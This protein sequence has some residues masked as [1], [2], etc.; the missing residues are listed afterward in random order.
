MMLP[1]C[2]G[3]GMILK[4]RWGTVKIEGTEA[5][6]WKHTWILKTINLRGVETDGKGAMFGE[7]MGIPSTESQIEVSQ[8]GTH[9]EVR[10]S[11]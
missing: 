10:C 6:L 3:H 2:S 9:D 5:A 1:P 11:A 7:H 8:T 4:K